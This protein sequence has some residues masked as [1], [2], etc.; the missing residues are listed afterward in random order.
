MLVDGKLKSF[1]C[2]YCILAV[3]RVGVGGLSESIKKGKFV[4]KKFFSDNIEWSSKNLW[5]ICE[6]Y[7][8]GV[9]AN[10]KQQ[11]IKDM[12]VVSL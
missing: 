1:C 7:S 4:K 5:K 2:T 6:G 9:K 3:K 12:A 11:E 8:P 10:V